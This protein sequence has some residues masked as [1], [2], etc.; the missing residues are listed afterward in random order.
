[1]RRFVASVLLPLNVS[2]TTMGLPVSG[3]V[4]APTRKSHTPGRRSYMLPA[5]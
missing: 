5:P 2:L 3:S 1:M 4:P